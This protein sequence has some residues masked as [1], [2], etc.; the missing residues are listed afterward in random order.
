MT[1]RQAAEHF[2]DQYA[3]TELTRTTLSMADK[4]ALK[5]VLQ[6]VEPN[7]LLN[8][9]VIRNDQYSQNKQLSSRF[10]AGD[11]MQ[12]LYNC[13]PTMCLKAISAVTI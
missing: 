3:V 12:C 4:E 7:I 11:S 1:V 10:N 6:T 9:V 13:R 8:C 2:H 5:Q